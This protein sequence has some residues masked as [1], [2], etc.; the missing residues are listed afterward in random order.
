MRRALDEFVIY[1]G[2]MNAVYI[3]GVLSVRNSTDDKIRS[4]GN[5]RQ[6]WD[7][8]EGGPIPERTRDLAL[9]WNRLL[10]SQGF[11]ET[12]AFPGSDGEIVV[13][14][15]NNIHYLEVIIEPDGSTSLAYDFQ[16]K[17]AFYRPNMSAMEAVQMI[18]DLAGQICGVSGYYTQINLTGNEA[19]LRGRRF[20]TQR[21]TDV[22]QSSAW[23]VSTLEDD[24]SA[25]TS[26]SFTK[27]T[28]ESWGTPRFFGSLNPIFYQDHTK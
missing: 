27:S 9:A 5:L 12:D 19:S 11:G 15:G 17:Q 28:P 22:F 20:V 7:Y 1:T 21:T 8:G 6:G 23:N 3:G 10:Q 14:A 18:I 16:G 24:Q 26:G 4:F 13:A 2:G 25:I